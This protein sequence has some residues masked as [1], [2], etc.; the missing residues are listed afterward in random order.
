M[1]MKLS[2]AVRRNDSH[3]KAIC[4]GFTLIELL[5]VLAIIGVLAGMILPA[6][7][8]AKARAHAVL[9]LNNTRQLTLAWLLYAEDNNDRLVYNLGNNRA[10]R[11][12]VR[13]QS[14]NWVDN[15]MDWELDPSNTNTAF[16]KTAKLAPYTGRSITI[17]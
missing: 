14:W 15:V 1:V 2:A 16:I 11:A 9:C 13:N 5:V 12:I 10:Q 4:R 6:L 8:K 17:Y 7:S 3:P